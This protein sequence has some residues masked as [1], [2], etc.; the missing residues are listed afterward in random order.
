MINYLDIPSFMPRVRRC[1]K[2][3]S[4]TVR[5]LC[6]TEPKGSRRQVI[7]FIGL[8]EYLEN[9]EFYDRRNFQEGPAGNLKLTPPFVPPLRG[10]LKLS[11]F[12]RVDLLKDM[13][14]LFG[15]MRFR[16]MALY[17]VEGMP[18]LLDACAKTLET[19]V[20][21]PDDPYGERATPSEGTHISSND[22]A[23]SSP[24]EDFD[25]SRIESL[26][27]LQVMAGSIDRALFHGSLHTASSLLKHA[28]STITSPSF[29]EVVV[30]YRWHDFC[31][32]ESWR[33]PDRSPSREVSQAERVVE[34]SW[35]RRRFEVLHEIHAVRD[36]R[37]V[38]TASV[39]DPVGEYSVRMLK[40]A[41]AE[42]KA[43]NIFDDF[44]SEPSVNYYPC[45]GRV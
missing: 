27:T 21:H 42:E 14:D 30:V 2:H 12:R 3:F 5:E 38:L 41:V 25:L 17:H 35:S 31:G 23:A 9:L 29:F 39:W 10:W 13:I 36:F 18:L 6:L 26:R 7:Y 19:L 11:S 24:L 4:P 32:V 15:G 20:L 43:T 44:H 22:F 1:F 45:R 33:H 34:A 28:L 16:R 8:F 40:E 37:L